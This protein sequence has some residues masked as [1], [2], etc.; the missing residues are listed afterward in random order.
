MKRSLSGT[1]PT[2]QLIDERRPPLREE[3]L[4]ALLQKVTAEHEQTFQALQAARCEADRRQDEFL[5]TLAH[6]LRD[7][8]ASIRSAVQIMRMSECDQAT[9]AAA[10]AMIERQLKH[11]VQFIDELLDVSRI[12]QGKLE[13]RR[14]RVDLA[15]I[16]QIAI[17]ANR[18]LL[19]SKQQHVRVECP[20]NLCTLKRM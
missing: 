6:E 15:T 10:C 13:L 14:A 18:P 8:L 19:E 2:Q 7:P 3:T 4:T 1:L 16:I 17:E 12:T 11:L 5:T 9:A 20:R